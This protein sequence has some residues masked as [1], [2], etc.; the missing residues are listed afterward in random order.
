[1]LSGPEAILRI[2]DLKEYPCRDV[3][4]SK[5]KDLELYFFDREKT[6][7]FTDYRG[8]TVDGVDKRSWF[9]SKDELDNIAKLSKNKKNSLKSEDFIELTWRD[10]YN[11]SYQLLF[12][13]VCYDRKKEYRKYDV[14]FYRG[15]TIVYQWI[16][17][18]ETMEKLLNEIV[19]GKKKIDLGVCVFD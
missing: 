6:L 10:S 9:I 14:V 13:K 5:L 17:S 1:M 8:S 12:N 15:R 3:L 7:W 2:N 16:L 11:I 4:A 18:D 19:D